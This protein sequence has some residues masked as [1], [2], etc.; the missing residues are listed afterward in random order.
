[1]RVLAIPY[2]SGFDIRNRIA[3]W[4]ICFGKRP[5]YQYRSGKRGSV[6][7]FVHVAERGKPSELE[8]E[9]NDLAAQWYRETR[10]LSFIRQKATH[11]AYQQIIGM[12]KDALPFIF[13]ELQERGGDW[14]WA[15][16]YIVRS[17][18]PAKGSTSF[19]ETVRLWLE[20]ART[21]GHIH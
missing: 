6:D 3:A 17:E 14:I 2:L 8:M 7:Y 11:P 1:M 21:K 9:F 5:T 20:W 10:M 15:L 13:R 19:K 16:E 18:N 12:G 4:P